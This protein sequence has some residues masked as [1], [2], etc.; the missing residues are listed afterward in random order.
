MIFFRKMLFSTAAFPA[1]AIDAI[2]SP[3]PASLLSERGEQGR[4]AASKK[5]S[6]RTNRTSS[7]CFGSVAR[8]FCGWRN[9]KASNGKVNRYVSGN[10]KVEKKEG[11][12]KA[13]KMQ[14]KTATIWALMRWI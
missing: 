4:Q 6:L 9:S 7:T 2:V 14:Q 10:A 11:R 1:T 5:V 12:R 8:H 3:Y 13:C